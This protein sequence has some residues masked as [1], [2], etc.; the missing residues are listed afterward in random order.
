MLAAS[1]SEPFQQR[2]GVR[3]PR[4]RCEADAEALGGHA[5][6][7]RSQHPLDARAHVGRRWRRQSCRSVSA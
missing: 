7:R 5:V 1:G 6:A 2:D 4:E 3:G